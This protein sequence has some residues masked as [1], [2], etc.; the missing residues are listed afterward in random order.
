M[1]TDGNKLVIFSSIALYYGDTYIYYSIRATA[2][3]CKFI[4]SLI[5]LPLFPSPSFLPLPPC[6][7]TSFLPKVS[8]Y[9]RLHVKLST[10]AAVTVWNDE[11]VKAIFHLVMDKGTVAE[12][13]SGLEFGQKVDLPS[14]IAFS[15]Q[16]LTKLFTSEGQVRP[17]QHLRWAEWCF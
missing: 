12:V 2:C 15:P 4:S 11:V 14:S 7:L 17:F 13:K 16:L 6:F 1:N 5:F 9:L 10:T 3:N 8:L